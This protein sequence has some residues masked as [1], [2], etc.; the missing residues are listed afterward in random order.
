MSGK[1]MEDDPHL[2]L[3]C[4]AHVG[5]GSS[6]DHDLASFVYLTTSSGVV[7]NRADKSVNWIQLCWQALFFWFSLIVEPG[8][9][10]LQAD[11]LVSE[12]PG[13]PQ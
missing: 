7:D 8:S 2:F 1:A 10:A 5:V 4:G 6:M 12:P 3:F 9:P 11:S 13:K